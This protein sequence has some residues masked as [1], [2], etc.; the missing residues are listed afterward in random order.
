[1]ISNVSTE[2]IFNFHTAGQQCALLL[3]AQFHPS[4]SVE[5]GTM[6]CTDDNKQ[7]TDTAGAPAQVVLCVFVIH[8]VQVLTGQDSTGSS[9]TVLMEA[10]S[11]VEEERG[12]KLHNGQTLSGH[13]CSYL[14]HQAVSATD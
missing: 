9:Y 1:M 10:V 11:Q 14:V 7:Y 8:T 4:Q 2:N 12:Y 6:R 5:S 3:L 13:C